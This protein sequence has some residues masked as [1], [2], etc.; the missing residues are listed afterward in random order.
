MIARRLKDRKHA[1]D[2]SLRFGRSLPR[3]LLELQELA[4]DLDMCGRTRVVLC[5]RQSHGLDEHGFSPRELAGLD[6]RGRKIH[7]EGRAERIVIDRQRGRPFEQANR[8]RKIASAQSSPP[9]GFQPPR[10]P[11]CQR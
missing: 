9:R 2:D 3:D 10:C 1:L 8:R 4:L 6:L 7:E 11:G 5:G